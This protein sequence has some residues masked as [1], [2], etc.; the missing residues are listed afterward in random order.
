MVPIIMVGMVMIGKLRVLPLVRSIARVVLSKREKRRPTTMPR[1]Q[2]KGPPFVSPWASGGNEDSGDDDASSPV[3]SVSLY[4]GLS[5][6]PRLHHI[7]FRFAPTRNP[8]A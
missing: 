1:Q 2:P 3:D 5:C 6:L 7:S 4:G 8:D